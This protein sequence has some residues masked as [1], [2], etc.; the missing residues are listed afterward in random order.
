MPTDLAHLR[1]QQNNNHHGE[2]N[3][4]LNVRLPTN[5]EGIADLTNEQH[6]DVSTDDEEE[7]ENNVKD[8]ATALNKGGKVNSDILDTLDRMRDDIR[9]LNLGSPQ[10]I[11]LG[12]QGGGKSTTLNRFT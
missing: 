1:Q 9:L 2:V 11:V 7:N 6:D 3:Q 4:Q 5:R 10:I 8:I 12:D